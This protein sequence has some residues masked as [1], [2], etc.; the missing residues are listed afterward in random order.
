MSGEFFLKRY[1][2]LLTTPAGKIAMGTILAFGFIAGVVFHGSF[3]AGMSASSTE[4]FCIGCHE[5][6]DNVYEEYKTTIHYSN[7]TG[8][9][10]E[11]ADCHLPKEWI[12]KMTRKLLASKELYGKLTG[13]IDTREKFQE[14]RREMAER[15]WARMK[16][17]DSQECRN[18]HN[19]DNMDFT[20]QS[21]RAIHY[22]LSGLPGHSDKATG[23][24]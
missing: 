17:N 10:A 19:F 16:A 8:V 5:M 3:N 14:H 13:K 20:E 15:E 1:W 23:N 12:P 2:R 9:T 4:A 6:E 24:R 21:S 22:A 7:R 11:C 18:C